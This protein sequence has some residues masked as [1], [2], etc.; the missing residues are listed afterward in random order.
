MLDKI[1]GVQ[2][3]K[4]VSII[5]KAGTSTGYSQYAYDTVGATVSG[6]IYPSID[7]M[8][9]EVKYLDRDIQGRVVTL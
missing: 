6:V 1:K 3:V 9:F 5:N 2:T 4:N 7:P 8:I